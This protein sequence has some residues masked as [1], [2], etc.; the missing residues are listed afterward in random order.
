MR[1]GVSQRLGLR[2]SLKLG[3]VLSVEGLGIVAAR[4]S[5]E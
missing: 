5:P 4:E 3:F 1:E 2:D